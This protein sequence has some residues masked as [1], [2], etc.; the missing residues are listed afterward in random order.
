MK[1]TITKKKS[2]VGAVWILKK[3]IVKKQKIIYK[4]EWYRT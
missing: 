4:K 1:N 2:S 3:K